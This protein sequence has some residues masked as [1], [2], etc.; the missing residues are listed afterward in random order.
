MQWPIIFTKLVSRPVA[1]V[2]Q[3]VFTFAQNKKMAK[4]KQQQA[5]IETQTTALKDTN[6]S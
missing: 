3:V 4:Q 1:Q 5:E 6:V 2:L